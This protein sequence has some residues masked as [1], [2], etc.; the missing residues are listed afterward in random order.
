MWMKET[1][2]WN[3]KDQ[4][5]LRKV[6]WNP[7]RL[8][9]LSKPNALDDR[10]EKSAAFASDVQLICSSEKMKGTSWEL[11][12]WPSG[13]ASPGLSSAFKMSS[14]IPAASLR[15]ATS[16][17]KCLLWPKLTQRQGKEILGNIVPVQPN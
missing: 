15:S 2:N 4:L 9:T 13:Q 16:C 5:G 8:L 10:Q 1:T 17:A 3:H 14:N 7:Q 6:N 11:E 12:S